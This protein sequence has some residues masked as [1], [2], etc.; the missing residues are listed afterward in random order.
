[1]KAREWQRGC[2]ARVDPTLR[3]PA[4]P[5][6]HKDVPRCTERCSYHDGKR[7]ELLGHR[8]DGIC[9][10]VVRQMGRLLSA[11]SRERT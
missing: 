7:C 9:E 3:A 1:M 8:P 5:E 6:W 11:Q 4:T 10:P 2:A